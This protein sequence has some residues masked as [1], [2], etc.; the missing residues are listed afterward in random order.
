MHVTY[1]SGPTTWMVRCLRECPKTLK[2]HL[3]LGVNT[4]GAVITLWVALRFAATIEIRGYFPAVV[5]S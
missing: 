2:M 3:F 4:F 1:F 5:N